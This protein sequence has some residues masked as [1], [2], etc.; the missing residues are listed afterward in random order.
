MRLSLKQADKSIRRQ[1]LHLVR[2]WLQV[3]FIACREFA[4]RTLASLVNSFFRV[5]RRVNDAHFVRFEEG[6][7][8][9]ARVT[10]HPALSL[11]AGTAPQR[12]AHAP[13]RTATP[14]LLSRQRAQDTT[15]RSTPT[16]CTRGN[17][18]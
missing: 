10:P 16:V 18:T 3:T 12:R 11:H 4:T 9:D 14:V 15:R 13:P 8:V 1:K 6:K 5:S 17:S 2:G 7:M